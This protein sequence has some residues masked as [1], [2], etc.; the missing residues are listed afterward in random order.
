MRETQLVVIQPTPLCNIN[1]RYCYLPE[2]THKQRIAMQTVARIGQAFFCSPFAGESITIVWHAGEPL[3]LPIDF[4]EQ[5]FALLQAQN[6]RGVQIEH[7]IQTNATL[8]TPAWCDFFRRQRV[9]IG[10]SLDGPQAVHDANRLD[11]KGA[12]TFE[13]TM[14]GVNLLKQNGIPFSVLAVVTQNSLSLAREFWNF[15]AEIA[16]QRLCLNPEEQEGIHLVSSLHSEENIALYRAFLQE[17]LICNRQAARPLEIR[18]F[19][20]VHERIRLGKS[21][22]LSQTNLSGA[23]L[24]FDWAGNISTFSPE[25]LTMTFPQRGAFHFGNV[26]THTLEEA[27][28]SPRCQEVQAAI[29]RGVS[30]CRQTCEYFLFC[31]GGFPSNKLSEHHTCE[32]G[33]TQACRLRI[34]TTVD[35][36]LEYLEQQFEL[37]T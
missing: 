12:G 16:P 31:G 22:A 26:F 6:T 3:V 21:W 11:R 4:Y 1:C 32:V 18:E 24:S 8:I 15:F 29:Q 25:M 17:L 13:R 20:R 14:R 19:A 9:K 7:Y 23:I 27:L 36:V 35:V 2:R 34:K 28:S 33:E 37:A 10:V 30:L 5:A